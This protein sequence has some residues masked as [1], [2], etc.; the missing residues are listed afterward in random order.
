MIPNFS[1]VSILL[2]GI[3]ASDEALEDSS[4]IDD[5]TDWGAKPCTRE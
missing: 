3:D 4:A 1:A 5:Y 2:M